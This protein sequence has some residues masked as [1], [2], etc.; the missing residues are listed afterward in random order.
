MS[1]LKVILLVALIAIL[2]SLGI[3][4]LTR[5]QTVN[6]LESEKQKPHDEAENNYGVVRY[7]AIADF[8]ISSRRKQYRIGDLIP[9]ELSM[10][11]KSPNQVRLLDIDINNEFI[12]RDSQGNKIDVFSYS[13]F[14][15]ISPSFTIFN[16]GDGPIRNFQ[17]F[18]GCDRLRRQMGNKEEKSG[19]D[20]ISVVSSGCFEIKDLGKYS[21]SVQV[22]NTNVE[23][24]HPIQTAVGEIESTP[25]EITIVE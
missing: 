24:G 14:Q 17:Y 8:K 23:S 3:V 9:F 11:N 18:V 7:Q 13:S 22:S 6:V 19:K 21:V 20:A 4:L 1:K 25:F 2:A 5:W 15:T 16:S 12:V 10:R